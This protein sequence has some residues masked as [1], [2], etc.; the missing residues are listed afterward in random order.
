MSLTPDEYKKL[1]AVFNEALELPSS[2]REAYL[3]D[4]A[5][6]GMRREL[7]RMLAAADADDDPL[8]TPA[9]EQLEIS[10]LPES[11]GGF[12]IVREIGRGG[13]GSVYEG[14]RIAENFS[15]RA[16]VKVIRNGMNNDIILRRFLSEQK[17]LASLEHPN[18]ARFLDGGT[19]ARGLPFYAME[20]V[21]GLPIGAYARE[22]DLSHREIVELFRQ[23]CSAVSYAHSQLVVHRDLKPSNILVDRTGTLKLLDF[24]IAKVLETD[25]VESET[26][27]QFGMMTPQYASPE[28]I[29]GEKIT[30][31]SDV[32]SLGMI[33]HELL[34]GEPPYHTDT[35]TYAEILEM[36]S[37]D[38]PVRKP[39]T[40]PRRHDDLF[41][42]VSKAIRRDLEH[43]YAS[44]E[45]FS[46]DLSRWL[47]G[48]PVTA[49]AESF[50]YKLSKFVQRNRVAVVAS[51]VVFVSLLTGI[52]IAAWQARRAEEQRV[53]AERRFAEV[54]TLA[55][56]VVFKY[57]DEIAKLDGSTGV[58]EMLVTDALTYLDALS[59]DAAGDT[60][61]QRELALAYIK[62]GDV[63]GKLYSANAGNT[64]GSI[65]SYKKAVALFENALT[66]QPGDTQ[67][68][69]DLV[70][71]YDALLFSLNRAPL[72]ANA[73]AGL[74]QRS[75]ELLER[76]V[77]ANPNDL[78]LMIRL[79]TY[80]IR[81]GDAYGTNDH[82]EGLKQKLE[83]HEKAL[84]IAEK[85][86]LVNDNDPKR[87]Q[88]IARTY[89][90]L[91]TD[92]MW[93]G[94]AALKLGDKDLAELHFRQGVPYHEKMVEV[95]ERVATLEPNASESR[96][97]QIAAYSS[98]AELL[99]HTPRTQEALNYA[100]QA[101]ILAKRGKELDP[102]N[103]EADME[104]GNVASVT[105][106]IHES[107]HDLDAAAESFQL[108]YESFRRVAGRDAK[109]VE[110]IS[111][112]V[113]SC[114]NLIRL[115]EATGN[116]SKLA[117]YKRIYNQLTATPKPA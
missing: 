83:L 21:E 84:P 26:A 104:I 98:I 88:A 89:Q 6:T 46:D 74:L 57:H 68:T 64:E 53:L 51:G 38:R 27:T 3:S 78:A 43:R 7:E 82:T 13:M 49:R 50:G 52:V 31:A 32:Y 28:Q 108:A 113:Q 62:L 111:G 17:I 24:G 81:S 23:V 86:L 114:K 59:A 94:E 116:A 80:H 73:K 63:Q 11:I 76:L 16:A 55:N 109:N 95:M 9:I 5:D 45:S 10:A 79:A 75:G 56:N 107:S 36:V 96:R 99:S 72:G 20:F 18:I 25:N 60:G 42:I 29:R 67:I 44:V 115:F 105:G 47:V 69:T 85:L 35:K 112:S 34:Y 37:A 110:A 39:T 93:L 102:G 92:H 91:G 70:E 58:R 71:A 22:K 15:Q 33:L 90:R 48:L 61:L 14:T 2:D 8:E 54:R 106:K 77:A 1:K 30:T 66:N 4:A 103:R 12:R 117:E 40:Q 65:E 87:L 97:L 41:R 101:S 100:R 19:T